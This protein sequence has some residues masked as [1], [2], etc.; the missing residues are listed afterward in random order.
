[1]IIGIK[2]SKV[3]HQ[4]IRYNSPIVAPIVYIE[5]KALKTVSP[6]IYLDSIANNDGK[7]G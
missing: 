5:V 1:M 6:F 2:K 7:D 4:F 3:V